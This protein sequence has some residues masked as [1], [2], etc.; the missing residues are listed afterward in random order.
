MNRQYDVIKSQLY[1]KFSWIRDLCRDDY[2]F[3][4]IFGI[5]RNTEGELQI[6]GVMVKRRLEWGHLYVLD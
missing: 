4:V 2:D 1:A 6:P 5:V 3:L